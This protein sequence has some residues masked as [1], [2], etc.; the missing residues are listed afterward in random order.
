MRRILGLLLLL[1]GFFWLAP[2][3]AKVRIDIDLTTQTMHVESSSGS[4]SWPVSTARAGYVTPRG[5]FVPTGMQ[6][7]HYS[8]KYDNS[9]MP[10]S[11][12]F[13]GGFAIHGTYETAWLGRPASHGCVRLDPANAAR[14]YQMVQAKGASITISGTPPPSAPF[15]ARAQHGAPSYAATQQWVFDP[16]GR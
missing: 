11:I 15:Y 13:A 2:A 3:E 5:S 12:F 9:P 7:M 10:Y 16:F 1:C 4:Y 14:L 6:R 8:R